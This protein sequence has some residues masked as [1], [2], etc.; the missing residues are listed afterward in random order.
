MILAAFQAHSKE[1]RGVLEVF[2]RHSY[3]SVKAIE[4]SEK[5][6]D[7]TP[8]RPN[9]VRLIDSGGFAVIHIT[10]L[11]NYNHHNTKSQCTIKSVI[12]YR[13]SYIGMCS[14]NV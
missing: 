5:K 6:G 13:Q 14:V 3:D 1:N 12:S 2:E 9:A 8:S 7:H 4:D 11:S 10:L